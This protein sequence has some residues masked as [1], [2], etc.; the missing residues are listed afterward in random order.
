MSVRL[1]RSPTAGC[2]SSTPRARGEG[3][4]PALDEGTAKRD[5]ALGPLQVVAGGL[6][7]IGDDAAAVRDLMRPTVALYVG[8]MGAPGRNFYFDLV[9][10]YGYEAAATAVQEHYLAGRKKDAEAA[11]PAE[12]LEKLCLVARGL[13]PRPRRGLPRGG[14]DHAQR[15]PRRPRPRPTDRAREELAVTTPERTPDRPCT[16]PTTRPSARRCGPS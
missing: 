11:V 3:V 13:R 16:A 15:H 1:P 4:G 2:R 7:A 8:G 9:C 14:R 10:S 6:L 5:P 12:L